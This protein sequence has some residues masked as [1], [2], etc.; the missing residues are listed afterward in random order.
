MPLQLDGPAG[1][2]PEKRGVTGWRS[3]GRRVAC[4]AWMGSHGPQKAPGP[5]QG[6]IHP[7]PKLDGGSQELGRT[8]KRTGTPPPLGYGGHHAPRRTPARSPL[9]CP[10]RRTPAGAFGDSR[11]RQRVSRCLCCVTDEHTQGPEATPAPQLS[12][13]QL[14]SADERSDGSAQ[15]PRGR[16]EV[17]AGPAPAAGSG[18][19]LPARSAVTGPGPQS[20]LA[21]GQGPL[22]PLKGIHS[23]QRALQPRAS[24]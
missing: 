10:P 23:P 2:A 14:R 19:L 12:S 22:S 6:Y 1:A 5:L 4:L 8:G 20:S 13:A 9:W 24:H 3:L 15:D 21:V 11:A 18:A 16:S 7:S 17:S